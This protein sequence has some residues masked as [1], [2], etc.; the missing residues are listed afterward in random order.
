MRTP[1]LTVLGGE[2]A[3][4]FGSCDGS[5]WAFQPRTG[6]PLWNYRMSRRG[7]SIDAGR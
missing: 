7:I 5:V 4:V 6:K 1:V 2:A 3:M